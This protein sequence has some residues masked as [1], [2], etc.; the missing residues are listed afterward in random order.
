MSPAPGTR[1]PAGRARAGGAA[2]PAWPRATR[3]APPP[4]RRAARRGASPPDGRVQVLDLVHRPR[5][6]ARRQVLPA[7]VAHDEHDVALV[8]LF[9][10]PHGDRGNRAR[11]DA[12]EDALLVE[13]PPRP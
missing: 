10:D 9:G 1:G 12:G 7:V 6:D 5:V 2:T 4:P 8:E 11:G 3:P 13:Q